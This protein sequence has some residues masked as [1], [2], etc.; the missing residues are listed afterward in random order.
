MPATFVAPL[1]RTRSAGRGRTIGFYV[2]SKHVKSMFTGVRRSEGLSLA[3]DC[4]V[5]LALEAGPGAAME[6]L[7]CLHK[8]FS[9]VRHFGAPGAP[10]SRAQDISTDQGVIA[11]C[12]DATTAEIL[13]T[14]GARALAYMARP[15]LTNSVAVVGGSLKTTGTVKVAGRPSIAAA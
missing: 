14:R 8:Y 13:F 7:S 2:I 11:G 6:Q 9:R 10:P 1:V 5:L 3:T 12:S 15:S 4:G